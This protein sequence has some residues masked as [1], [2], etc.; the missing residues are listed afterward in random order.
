M[1]L[2]AADGR[3]TD[4]AALLTDRADALGEGDEAIAH[5][6]RA[7]SILLDQSDEAR[8]A[9]DL[10]TSVVHARPDFVIAAELLRAAQRRLGESA[11]GDRKSTRL[12]SSHRL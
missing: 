10:L 5:R 12:N 11:L 2:L 8:R 3:W 1:R 6:Y 4:A 7:A 9:I